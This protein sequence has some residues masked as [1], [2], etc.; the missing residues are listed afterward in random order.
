MITNATRVARRYAATKTCTV[1]NYTEGS[2]VT[3]ADI[4]RIIGKQRAIVPGT[5][6]LRPTS[7]AERM[8]E[9]RFSVM[10]RQ[11]TRII[12][13]A[14]LLMVS[15]SEAARAYVEIEVTGEERLVSI[16]EDG[17]EQT[18]FFS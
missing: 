12:G 9:I 8:N 13:T 6:R 1:V 17:C 4:E 5:C 10:T 16:E 7:A 11:M 18:G 2:R 15:T 3:T 14:R